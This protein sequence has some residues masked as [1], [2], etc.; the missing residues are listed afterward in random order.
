M[1]LFL[2][3][4]LVGMFAS[5]HA[6]DKFEF[7]EMVITDLQYCDT[8]QGMAHDEWK[9]LPFQ[10]RIEHDKVAWLGD[11]AVAFLP[12]DNDKK[13][14][15]FI[16]NNV[17]YV[18]Y[19]DVVYLNCFGASTDG[20]KLGK[21]FIPAI[22][23]GENEFFVVKEGPKNGSSAPAAMFMFVSMAGGIA[24]DIAENISMKNDSLY[25]KRRCYIYNPFNKTFT[26]INK[27]N[28]D[29]LVNDEDIIKEL[30][31]IQ[32]RYRYS[33]PVIA[34]YFM[35]LGLI[36]SAPVGVKIPEDLSVYK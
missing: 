25:D 15:S 5:V 9:T 4:L 17:K 3:A 20:R 6:E 32:K 19:K 13:K 22:S 12:T 23:Y 26:L 28:I 8:Y 16:R 24:M 1:K 18:K 2:I 27:D 35:K 11:D 34:S 7:E 10:C 36:K 31:D 21:G 33:P 30:K 14:K 29:L